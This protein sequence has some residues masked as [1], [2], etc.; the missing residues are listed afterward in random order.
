MKIT[1]IA[2][3]VLLTSNAFASKYSGCEDPNYNA[4]VE[5]RLAFYEQLDKESYEKAMVELKINPFSS[6]DDMEKG[7]FLYRNTVLSARFDSEEVALKNI[8][9]FEEIEENKPFYAKS[10]NMPHLTNIAKGWMALNSGN[11]EEAIRYLL[12]STKTKG[13]STLGSFGPD[14]T[15][16][17]VLYKQGNKEAVLK[18]LELVESFWNTDNAKRDMEVWRKMAK[19]DCSIQFQFYDTTSIK[20]LGL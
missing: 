5:K 15:L 14:M 19:N 7:L 6:L 4:Y 2:I 8:S 20:E 16:I 18:Y 10:G 12:K 11:T 9:R 1:F 3:L 13:S 17:R